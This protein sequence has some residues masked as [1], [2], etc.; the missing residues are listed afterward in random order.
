M[1][2][3][4]DYLSDNE[5]N[6]SQRTIERDFQLLRDDFKIAI[7]FDRYANGYFIDSEASLNSESLYNFLEIAN[8]A[9]LFDP[10]NA[11][12]QKYI[13]FQKQNLRKNTHYLGP[14]IE[15]IDSNLKLELSYQTFY[16]DVT[17]KHILHP[18]LVREY[19]QRWYVYG[20]EE[21]SQHFKTYA[22]DRIVTVSKTSNSFKSKRIERDTIYSNVVGMTLSEE[23]PVAVVLKFTASQ[24]KYIST[25][26]LHHSQEEIARDAD[27]VTFEY[28]LTPNFEL[29]QKI[30]LHGEQVEVLQPKSLRE[31]ITERVFNLIK[32]YNRN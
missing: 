7:A 17:K 2:Q 32:I 21:S 30:L 22:L 3:L 26:P 20:Y 23:P 10:K 8:T 16:H 14:I 27:F 31:K 4:L 12:K 1:A 25:L 9:E 19:D 11:S 5:M 6:V 24:A 18:Y 28:M 13:Q 29:E 15:A